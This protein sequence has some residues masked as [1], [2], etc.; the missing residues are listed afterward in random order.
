M[1]LSAFFVVYGTLPTE[2]K[3]LDVRRESVFRDTSVR[4]EPPPRQQRVALTGVH[5]NV[6][7]DLLA[8]TVD[9]IFT[10]ECVVLLK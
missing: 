6:S 2:L 9:D 3:C 8:V 4:Q 10:G 5:V 1:I 7:I